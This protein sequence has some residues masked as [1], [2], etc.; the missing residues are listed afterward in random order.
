MEPLALAFPA[1]RYETHQMKINLDLAEEDHML[2]LMMC[3]MASGAAGYR[4]AMFWD[5][6]ALTNRLFSNSP[7]FIPY[8]IPEEHRERQA[9]K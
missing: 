6:V 7:D 8:E 4:S 9:R 3:G 1:H 5:I 2:L